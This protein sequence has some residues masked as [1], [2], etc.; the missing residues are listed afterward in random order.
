MLTNT[1]EIVDFFEQMDLISLNNERD[2]KTLR[3]YYTYLLKCLYFVNSDV[4]VLDFQKVTWRSFNSFIKFLENEEKQDGY[5]LKQRAE[6]ILYDVLTQNNR[7]KYALEW[8]IKTKYFTQSLSNGLKRHSVESQTNV[9]WL[10]LNQFNEVLSY[11]TKRFHG[12]NC[13]K[14]LPFP[15]FDAFELN[16][17]MQVTVTKHELYNIYILHKN[18]L[19]L[20]IPCNPE[21]MQ[22]WVI[23]YW[24]LISDKITNSD[25]FFPK[26]DFNYFLYIMDKINRLIDL[27]EYC[28]EIVLTEED[29]QQ[30]FK[31][32]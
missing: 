21:D 8:F 2:I 14:Y 5:S 13:T 3:L 27:F 24:P 30:I 32:Y 7:I 16:N 19:G 23:Y 10:L 18:D 6:S 28:F 17:Q 1:E 11:Y 9:K 31:H 26:N 20:D 12:L 22:E 15:Q 4:N 25:I 29:Y